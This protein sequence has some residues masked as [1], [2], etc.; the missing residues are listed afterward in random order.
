VSEYSIK[1]TTEE[2]EGMGYTQ[3]GRGG[4]VGP[5]SIGLSTTVARPNSC[6]CRNCY[7]L[8]REAFPV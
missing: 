7:I 5:M 6:V 3:E 8:V 2:E 4:K 1:K